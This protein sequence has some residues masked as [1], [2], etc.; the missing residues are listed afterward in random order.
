MNPIDCECATWAREYTTLWE[1][2]HHNCPSNRVRKDGNEVI[3][4]FVRAIEAWARDEDG[5]VHPAAW[6][7]YKFGKACIGEPVPSNAEPAP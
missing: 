6:D 4:R 7:V 1:S 2:H 3:E 5:E